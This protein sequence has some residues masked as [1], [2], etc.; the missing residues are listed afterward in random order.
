MKKLWIVSYKL[1]FN[2]IIIYY[3]KIAKNSDTWNI[4]VVCW[5]YFGLLACGVL[6]PIPLRLDLGW[7]R[8]EGPARQKMTHGLVDLLG[9]P[10]KEGKQTWRSSK[11]LVG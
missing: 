2:Y 9:V 7:P 3:L 5:I 8:P 1:F 11:I 4:I 10:R 6:T